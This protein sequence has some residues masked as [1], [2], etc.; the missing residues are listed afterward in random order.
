M[1]TWLTPGTRWQLPYE[2]R[3]NTRNGCQQSLLKSSAC[4]LLLFKYLNQSWNPS[5]APCI[6]TISA[7]SKQYRHV[8]LIKKA[9]MLIRRDQFYA[10]MV[11]RKRFGE[12]MTRRP[13][14]VDYLLELYVLKE[15]VILWK[16]FS[17]LAIKGNICV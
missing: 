10:G 11:H 14:P 4:F 5:F 15:M 17:W 12:V 9:N 7:N 8:L 2:V 16:Y 13:S 3:L 6:N 1:Q